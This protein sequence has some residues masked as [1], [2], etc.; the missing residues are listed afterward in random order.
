MGEFWKIDFYR[1]LSKLELKK[2]N[3]QNRNSDRSGFFNLLFLNLWKFNELPHKN[4]VKRSWAVFQSGVRRFD[5]HSR[6]EY[7]M[8]GIVFWK[9]KENQNPFRIFNYFQG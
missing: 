3:L 5:G 6:E 1:I 4:S 2:K 9:N 8:H 7:G